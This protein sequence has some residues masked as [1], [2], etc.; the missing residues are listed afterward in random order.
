MSEELC[1]PFSKEFQKFDP[2]IFDK[3]HP[4]LTGGGHLAIDDGLHDF[5]NTLQGFVANCRRREIYE[6]ELRREQGLRNS[7]PVV[8]PSGGVPRDISVTLDDL[9]GDRQFGEGSDD[10][11]P[12]D[13]DD[14]F[15]TY[16]DMDDDKAD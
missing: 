2:Q 1:E 13:G 5:R 14:Y 16:F 7:E 8:V 10:M 11:R 15:D 12:D 4:S 6:E 9:L 3:Q